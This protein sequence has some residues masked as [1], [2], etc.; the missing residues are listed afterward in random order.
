MGT[1][2]IQRGSEEL[3]T[4]V[5]TTFRSSEREVNGLRHLAVFVKQNTV[6]WAPQ[7]LMHNSD[8]H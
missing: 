1:P 8:R 7:R 5:A 3:E 2:K 4:Y 6:T